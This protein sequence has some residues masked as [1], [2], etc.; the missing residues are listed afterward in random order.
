MHVLSVAVLKEI[1]QTADGVEVLKAIVQQII[2]KLVDEMENLPGIVICG[3]TFNTHIL[4]MGEL[5]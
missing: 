3:V 1:E 5:H 4:Q 2:I